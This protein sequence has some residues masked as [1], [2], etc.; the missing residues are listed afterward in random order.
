MLAAG[1]VPA[2]AQQ[3]S[4][5]P[6]GWFKVCAKQEDNDICNTQNIVTAD[7]GQLLTAVN[8]IEIKGKVNRRVFQIAVPPGRLIPPGVGM[9]IDDGKTMKVDYSVCFPDRCIAET[10]LTDDMVS[11]FK[12]GG[13]VTLTSINFQNKQNPIKVSLGGFTDA[14]TGPGMQPSDVQKRQQQLQQE[15]E[16]HRADFEKRLQQEQNKAKSG[17]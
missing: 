11:A 9:Q 12:K 15:I 17:N 16:K 3:N 13:T 4:P 8:L 5:P 14:Y 10:A 7:N 6:Q 1:L 2:D